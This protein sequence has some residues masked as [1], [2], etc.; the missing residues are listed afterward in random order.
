[1][2]RRS[3]SA[4]FMSDSKWRKLI[5][6]VHA[7]VPQIDQMLVKF[8]DVHEPRRMNFPP[9]LRCP[10]AYVDTIE[11]GPVELRAIEW[12]ELPADISSVLERLGQFPVLVTD[13][14][15]KIVGY[16]GPIPSN[17]R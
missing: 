7:E 15:S 10:Q 9:G 6:A 12:L 2:A 11:F 5:A 1:M 13:G 3:F 4:A 14:K 8:I 17:V 16:D